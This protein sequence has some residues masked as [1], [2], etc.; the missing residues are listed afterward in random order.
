MTPKPA[1]GNDGGTSGAEVEE[2]DDPFQAEIPNIMADIEKSISKY[3]DKMAKM[4]LE[5]TRGADISS[6]LGPYL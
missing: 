6:Y 1:L 3:A 4:V 5:Y 2:A